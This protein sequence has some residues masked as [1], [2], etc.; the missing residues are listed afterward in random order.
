MRSEPTSKDLES[1]LY[2][3]IWQV[4]KH[5]DADTDGKGCHGCTG[6]DVMEI[7]NSIDEFALIHV[8]SDEIRARLDK[9]FDLTGV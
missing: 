6:T 2:N 9:K 8:F 3:A 5:W 1:P 7:I 4:I